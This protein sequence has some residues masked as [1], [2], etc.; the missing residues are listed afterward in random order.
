[1]AVFGTGW[2]LAAQNSAPKSAI[3]GVVLDP[4]EAAVSGANVTL[5]TRE[6]TV[7]VAVKTDVTGTF[8]FDEVTP[9]SYTL[10]IE[11]KGFEA[12]A[13]RIRV[14]AKPPPALVIRLKVAEIK[15]EVTVT[16]QSNQLSVNNT[17]NQNTVSLDRQALDNLPIFDQD[18]VTTMSRFL[19]A[20]AV[21][22]GGVTLIVDG[23]EATRAPVSFSAIQEVKINQ[24]PYSAEFPRPGRGRIEIITKPQSPQFHGVFNFLFRDY[25]LNARDPFS[26]TRPFEQR[27]IFEGSF[28]GPLGRGGK[29][30]F[31]ISANRQEEDLQAIVFAQGLAGP[32]QETL[33]TP[34]RNTELGGSITHLIGE[35]L[36]SLRG[37]YTGK[38]TENQGVGGFNLPE[39]A[40]NLEDR[41]DLLSFN[42]RGPI[43]RRFYNLFRFYTARQ[44]TP[45]TSVNSAPKIV[46]VG[47][48]T[49]GGAQGDR[50]QTENH[51]AL[52]ETIVWSAQKHTV[53]FG[54]N[55]PD[56]SRRGLDDNTNTGGTYTFASL[57][58]YQL[59]RPFSLVRQSGNGHVVFVEKVLGGFVQDEFKLRPNLQI[60]AGLRYDWQNYFDYNHAFA[61]RTSFAWSPG[62]SRKFVIR[63]GG[64]VFYDR[65]GPQPIFDLMRYDG[66]GLLQ[67]VLT[68][69]RYPDPSGIGPTS[70]VRLDPTVKIPYLIQYGTGVE[71]QLKKSTTLSL[72]YYG[73]RG[74]D[75]FRSRDVNAPPPPFYLAHPDPQYSVWRQIESSA[76][77]KSNSLELA[78]RG[79]VTRYFSGMIQYTLAKAYNNTGGNA[80]AGSRTSLTSFP[81]NDYDLHGEWA[82]A[83]YDQRHRFNLLGS[84][85]PARYLKLG[86]ALALYSGMPYSMTTGN[87]DFNN[88]RGGS[89]PPGTPRNSLHG[90][91]YADIDLRWSHDFSLEPSRKDK[92]PVATI[93]LDAFDAVNHVNYA[94]Y[95]GILSSPFFGKP[96]S[97]LPTRRMQISLRLQF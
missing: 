84:A 42:H 15:S 50:L 59:G 26:L 23:L 40:A 75:L 68:D 32:I 82:R 29:T 91:G 25:H 16:E 35:H 1:L 73:T 45:T 43:T 41:E 64:G 10:T 74:I 30:S 4:A 83:D 36:I 5:Q 3:T 53:R 49:G 7:L 67:Y 70:I 76:D 88:G 11:Q 37:L 48:F 27:R 86:I 89:R 93:A 85:T 21:A 87:D 79:A 63:G 28:T 2:H 97:A 61:P 95:V 94:S 72:N 78:L 66:Y 80:L 71:R 92:S 9:G 47:A 96:V 33:P 12:A 6:G 24:D 38:S 22:T 19:D 60:T 69:P 44:H 52:S 34:S 51:I 58:D 57:A 8:R 20:G 39:T 46:V 65:T 81:A 90:P 14:G 31:L 56:I 77:L 54:V 13:A 17:D 18:Y 62:K 55:V